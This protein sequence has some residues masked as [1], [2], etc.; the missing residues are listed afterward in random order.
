M[1]RVRKV[2]NSLNLDKW[3]NQIFETQ[4]EPVACIVSYTVSPLGFLA[5][6]VQEYCRSAHT[7]SFCKSPQIFNTATQAI[8]KM[9]RA[10]QSPLWKLWISSVRKSTGKQSNGKLMRLIG[11]QNSRIEV[12][13][14]WWKGYCCS[15]MRFPSSMYQKEKHE[16][17][18]IKY[19]KIEGA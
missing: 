2:T 17:E 12:Q 15:R 3:K 14:K 4:I 19:R 1:S 16:K 11:N 5:P 10:I 18:S 9:I 13:M 7:I 8:L 6:I